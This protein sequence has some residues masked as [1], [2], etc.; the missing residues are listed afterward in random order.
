MAVLVSLCYF[1]I[2]LLIFKGL[3]TDIPLLLQQVCILLLP[4]F[5]GIICAQKGILWKAKQCS[6]K[7]CYRYGGGDYP[8][9]PVRYESPMATGVV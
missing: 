1:A 8:H 3:A 4:F 5:L 6:V 7:K 2:K 9:A